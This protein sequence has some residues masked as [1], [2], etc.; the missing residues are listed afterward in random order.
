M[1][2]DSNGSL[3]AE[4]DRITITIPNKIMAAAG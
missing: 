2:G 3:I 4:L 1:G